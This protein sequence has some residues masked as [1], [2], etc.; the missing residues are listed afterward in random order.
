M[1]GLFYLAS[2]SEGSSMLSNIVEFPFSF[3][4]FLRLNHIPLYVYRTISLSIHPW[5]D[6]YVF[7]HLGYCNWCL[8]EHKGA[9]MSGVNISD[10]SS[11]GQMPRSG[12]ARSHNDSIFNFWRTS[13]LLSLVT[14][15]FCIS[16]NSMQSFQFLCIFTNTCCLLIVQYF[17]WL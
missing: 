9:N 12:I 16:I 1:T 17:V 3:S 14:E 5:M 13:T 7:P 11:F 2:C 10:F 15:I 6:A 4:F 8:S